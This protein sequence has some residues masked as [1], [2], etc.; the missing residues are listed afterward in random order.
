MTI[1]GP[2]TPSARIDGPRFARRA[3]LRSPA[4]SAAGMLEATRRSLLRCPSGFGG[5]EGRGFSSSERGRPLTR[6]GSSKPRNAAEAE[7]ATAS[8]PSLGQ[9]GHQ[10]RG[11]R[12]VNGSFEECLPSGIVYASCLHRRLETAEPSPNGSL[13]GAESGGGPGVLGWSPT[14]IQRRSVGRLQGPRRHGRHRSRP[15]QRASDRQSHALGPGRLVA[16]P[17]TAP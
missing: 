5:M 3:K 14:R 4:Q 13:A 15:P 12:A 6:A 1:A 11:R 10:G 8:T 16:P 7:Q 9:P 2:A 17:R